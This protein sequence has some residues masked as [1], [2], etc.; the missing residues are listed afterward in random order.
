MIIIFKI[1]SCSSLSSVREE[2]LMG[3][4]LFVYLSVLETMETQFPFLEPIVCQQY[5]LRI[6]LVAQEWELVT[7]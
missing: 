1:C 3:P 5:H 2:Q 4:S 6:P 7:H